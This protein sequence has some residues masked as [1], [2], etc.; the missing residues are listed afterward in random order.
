[1]VATASNEI[2]AASVGQPPS[3]GWSVAVFLVALVVFVLSPVHQFSDG[4]YSLLVSECLYRQGTFALDRYIQPPLDPALYPGSSAGELPYH[5]VESGGHVYY[6]FPMGTSILSVPFALLSNAVGMSAIFPE[7]GYHYREERRMQFRLAAL[8]MA[9]FALVVFRLGADLLGRRWAMMVVVAMVLGT[10][11][12]STASR[13]LWSH[14]WAI[15]LVMIAVHRLIRFEV[16]GNRLRPVLLASLLSWAFLTRP[17]MVIALVAVGGYL[18]FRHREA[19]RP[20]LLT[21][22]AWM[23]GL[24]VFSWVHF[25]TWLPPYFRATRLGSDEF[26]TALAGTLVS[27]SRGVLIFLPQLFLVGYLLWRYRGLMRLKALAVAALFAAT[28]HLLVIASFPHWWGGHGYGPRLMTDAVPWFVVL[29][30]IGTRA[31]LDRQ[32]EQ[33]TTTPSLRIERACAGVLVLVAVLMH[34]VGA[35][36]QRSNE[37]NWR[38]VSIDTRPERIWDWSDP[39]FLAPWVRADHESGP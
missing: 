10:Q 19:V 26:L 34:G 9:A 12:W 30:V 32:G 14:S 6:Y 38:P 25:G 27:P 21:V 8:L 7:G 13:G 18:A 33:T 3:R 20:F 4:S 24:V 15:L 31:W 37:W 22:G 36:S 23:S 11:V 29:A 2:S 16:S 17:T 28:G 39:Q 1:M 35:M 5:M